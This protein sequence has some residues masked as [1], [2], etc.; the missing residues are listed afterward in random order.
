MF[1]S[2]FKKL[3]RKSNKFKQTVSERS[4]NWGK[5]KFTPKAFGRSEPAPME[6]EAKPWQ[7]VKNDI[8]EDEHEQQS[9][10]R[11]NMQSQSAKEILKQRERNHRRNVI[12]TSRNEKP[13]WETFDDKE[14]TNKSRNNIVE[15]ITRDPTNMSFKERNYLRRKLTKAVIAEKSG[16]LKSAINDM[17]RN[18]ITNN[19]FRK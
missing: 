6:E 5:R 15:N 9:A 19:K 11:F 2:D 7:H 10:D 14:T 8:L 1:N 18:P 13:K 12:E 4:K 16:T 17:K 3:Q